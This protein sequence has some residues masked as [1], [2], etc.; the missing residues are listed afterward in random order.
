MSGVEEEANK[1]EILK[2]LI[3]TEAFSTLKLYVGGGK[4]R[5][6]LLLLL[7]CFYFRKITLVAMW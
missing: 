2:V 4:R 1:G 7:F 6:V 5:L 3:H